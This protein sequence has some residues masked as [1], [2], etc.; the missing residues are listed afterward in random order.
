MAT[1][2]VETGESYMDSGSVWVPSL[3]PEEATIIESINEES[4]LKLI[5][6]VNSYGLINMD[7]LERYM[8]IEHVL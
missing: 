3:N 4:T 1:P 2:V 6:N 7:T 8:V 5:W